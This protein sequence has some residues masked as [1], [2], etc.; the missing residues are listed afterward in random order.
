M[1]EEEDGTAP[2]SCFFTFFFPLSDLIDS[3]S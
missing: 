3:I 2:S 1:E